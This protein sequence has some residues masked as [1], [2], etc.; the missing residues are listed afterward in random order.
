MIT[1]ADLMRIIAD[2]PDDTQIMIDNGSLYEAV[3]VWDRYW[4]NEQGIEQE[5]IVIG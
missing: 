5:Y 1:K 4:L 3:M 2:L